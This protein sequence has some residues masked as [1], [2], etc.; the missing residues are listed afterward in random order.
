MTYIRFLCLCIE[1]KTSQQ[2]V[3]LQSQLS[4]LCLI[5]N[6]TSPVVVALNKRPAIDT[7]SWKTYP[8]PVRNCSKLWPKHSETVKTSP[9][10]SKS[11]LRL[12]STE[13]RWLS[14]QRSTNSDIQPFPGFLIEVDYVRHCDATQHLPQA[15]PSLKWTPRTTHHQHSGK[16]SRNFL[17]AACRTW[18]SNQTALF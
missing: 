13:L 17:P 3:A 11:T 5:N 6:N 2:P 7:S 8:T 15:P 9:V 4:E 14:N 16:M 1:S 12:V 10:V 18:F